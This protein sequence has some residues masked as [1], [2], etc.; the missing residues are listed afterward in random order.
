[1]LDPSQ[2]QGLVSLYYGILWDPEKKRCGTLCAGPERE[3]RVA[4]PSRLPASDVYGTR[5]YRLQGRSQRR[6][7]E[8]SDKL[9]LVPEFFSTVRK[10]KQENRHSNTKLGSAPGP[11]G[12]ATWEDAT[13]RLGQ[14]GVESCCARSFG[15]KH[16]QQKIQHVPRF[17]DRKELSWPR[18]RQGQRGWDAGLEGRG[19][20]WGQEAGRATSCGTLT[21][22]SEDLEFWSE[23]DG[24]PRTI[25]L[26]VPI[27]PEPHTGCMTL[28]E[29]FLSLCLNCVICK[30]GLTIKS[31]L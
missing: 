20:G 7:S 11:S 14:G 10:D 25:R 8:K 13:S 28:G 21:G 27:L 29:R 16:C 6:P 17:W 22:L 3:P 15:E 18:K 26:W 9:H 31:V 1:M 19:T 23:R 30:I 2:R 5:E 24:S 4:F 12:K